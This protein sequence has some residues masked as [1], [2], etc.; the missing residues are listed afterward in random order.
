MRKSNRMIRILFRSL[1]LCFFLLDGIVDN[2]RRRQ[3][4][5][6][7]IIAIKNKYRHCHQYSSRIWIV[8]F[9]S[10]DLCF[11]RKSIITCLSSSWIFFFIQD[12]PTTGQD[13]TQ[14]FLSF[15]QRRPFAP[16]HD[17][18]W[19]W[20]LLVVSWN[21]WVTRAAVDSSWGITAQGKSPQGCRWVESTKESFDRFTL[22]RST[23]D[24]LRAGNQPKIWRYHSG[25]GV[26][27]FGTFVLACLLGTFRDPSWRHNGGHVQVRDCMIHTLHD[28]HF[29]WLSCTILTIHFLYL[30]I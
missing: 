1:I 25:V 17:C 20:R 15:Q 18:I 14:Q 30:K 8:K 11:C 21:A 2:D 4:F 6:R 27:F 26:V 24:S 10:I 3:I 12:Q 22:W 16:Y 5:V 23:K 28:S 9:P 7:T 29:L 13:E 19:S